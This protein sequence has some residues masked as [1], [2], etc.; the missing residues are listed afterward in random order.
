MAARVLL[1]PLLLLL[2]TT[3][4]AVLFS[5]AGA[6]HLPGGA[7][8]QVAANG[9][10]DGRDDTKVCARARACSHVISLCTR[11]GYL[12]CYF[13]VQVY[14]V[15][16]ERQAATAAELPE[17]EAG[18]AIAALHHGMIGSVLGDGSNTADRVVYHYT[19]SLHG[20][21]ARLT[22]DEKNKLAGNK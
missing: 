12:I 6:V 17:E 20:F 3:L 13:R 15:F 16:T 18:A 14:V 21:A 9:A 5:H 22:Q 8:L 7:G 11:R 4:V 1:P 2:A 10:R 19:R